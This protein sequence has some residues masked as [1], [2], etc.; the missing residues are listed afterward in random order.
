MD[1]VDGQNSPQN[2]CNDSKWIQD[3]VNRKR[4]FLSQKAFDSGYE[5]VSLA[6]FGQIRSSKCSIYG[7][8]SVDY[9]ES[10]GD[11]DASKLLKAKMTWYLQVAYSLTR[12]TIG[13]TWNGGSFHEAI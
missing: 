3:P 12:L 5:T 4:L 7:N 8:C 10:I 6:I 2:F 13:T 11:M 9:L 1:M